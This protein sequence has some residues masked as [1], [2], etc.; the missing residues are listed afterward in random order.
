MIRNLE[1][2]FSFNLKPIMEILPV[3][4]Q[5]IIISPTNHN[6]VDTELG[7]IREEEFKKLKEAGIDLDKLVAVTYTPGVL[8][9]TFDSYQK[10]S[11]EII[12]QFIN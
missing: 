5:K 1:K 10:D 4:Q 12:V 8:N 2:H 6:I 11:Y 7:W 3:N 9:E